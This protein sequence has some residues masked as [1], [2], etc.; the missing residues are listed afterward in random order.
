M[1]R[2][3]RIRIKTLLKALLVYYGSIHQNRILRIHEIVQVL[4]CSKSNAYNYKRFLRRI[5]PTDP[6]DEDRPVGDEQRCLM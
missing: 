5:F 1:R 2:I 6:I 4:H 3:G